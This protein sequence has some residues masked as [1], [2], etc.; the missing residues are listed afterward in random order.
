MTK[1][2]YI[3]IPFCHQICKFC[4]FKRI[5]TLNNDKRIKNYVDKV[6]AEVKES[7]CLH[8]YKTIYLGGGTPNFLD[9]KLLNKL[10]SN[11]KKYLSNKNYEFTIE[12]NPDLI[13]S[14]QAIIFKKNKINRVSIGVQTTNNQI[15]K[16]MNRTHTIDDVINAINILRKNNI[17]NINCDFIYD[18][19]NLK[20]IDILNAF[21]FIKNNKIPHVSFY[22]LEIKNNSILKHENYQINQLDQENKMTYLQF[23]LN[24]SN[25]KRYEVSNWAISKQ[26]QSKHNLAYWQTKFWKGIGYGAAGFENLINYQIQGSIEKY[27]LVKE[28]KL[29]IH[30]YYFQIIMMGL[31]LKN[32]LDLKIKRNFL[33]YKYFENKLTNCTIKNNFLICNNIDLLD[34]LLI[35]L[36]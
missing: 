8:Q 28:N 15:L 11:L 25:Y 14:E 20:N 22:S 34:D 3:H 35:N 5:K 36:I 10:L 33:A 29:T 18:L 32:G 26:F 23:L 31:R 30:D 19:P 2:L 21:N 16:L 6:L 24:K 12:C 1:H 9:N 7:S 13:T 27:Y 4:D 17:N